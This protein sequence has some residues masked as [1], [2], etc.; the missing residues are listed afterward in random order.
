[1]HPQLAVLFIMTI[2]CE[3]V[4]LRCGVLCLIE[5]FVYLSG[6]RIYFVLL[7]MEI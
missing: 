5:V 6:L 4:F 2:I 7:S 1:M 3:R